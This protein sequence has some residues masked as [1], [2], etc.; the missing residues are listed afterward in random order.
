M[1]QSRGGTKHS[2]KKLR[3]NQKWFL[4]TNQNKDSLKWR[5]EHVSAQ[6]EP[7]WATGENFYYNVDLCDS[8]LLMS[9]NNVCTTAKRHTKKVEHHTHQYF[10]ISSVDFL[11]PMMVSQADH[12]VQKAEF[13]Q[14]SIEEC[15]YIFLSGEQKK[16]TNLAYQCVKALLIHG[17]SLMWGQTFFPV[18]PWAKPWL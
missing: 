7:C 12:A 8:M 18:N 6:R 3:R 9:N 10:C 17:Q 5:I 15:V 13:P 11:Q 1:C 16:N 2:I 14:Q 4:G